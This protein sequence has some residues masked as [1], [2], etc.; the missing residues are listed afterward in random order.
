MGGEW[1]GQPWKATEFFTVPGLGTHPCYRFWAMASFLTRKIFVPKK[2]TPPPSRNE[3]G[4]SF[5]IVTMEII[6]ACT[7][8]QHHVRQQ[9]RSHIYMYI[10]LYT[11]PVGNAQGHVPPAISRL[12]FSMHIAVHCSLLLAGWCRGNAL[13]LLQLFGSLYMNEVGPIPRFGSARR[14]QATRGW[15]SRI[16]TPGLN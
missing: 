5:R 2:L 4:K 15:F 3:V 10:I 14:V 1:A 8:T 7:V 11:D 6:M 16:C 13:L 9:Q 12:R